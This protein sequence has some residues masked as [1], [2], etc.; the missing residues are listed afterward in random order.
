MTCYFRHMQKIFEIAGIK[1]T[2]ANKGEIDRIIHKLVGIEYKNCSTTWKEV[3]KRLA[4]NEER[5][6][7]KLKESVKNGEE[8]MDD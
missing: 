3:K 5:F 8:I 6:I 7:T 2:N 1:I 4:E